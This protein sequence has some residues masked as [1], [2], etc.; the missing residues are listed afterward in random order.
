[1]K[2]IRYTRAEFWSLNWN[3]NEVAQELDATLLDMRF[4]KP[5]DRELMD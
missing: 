2:A 3:C 1:M 5:L 4:V